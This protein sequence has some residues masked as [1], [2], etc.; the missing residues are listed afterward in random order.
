MYEIVKRYTEQYSVENERERRDE[1]RFIE[2]GDKENGA[3]GKEKAKQKEQNQYNE[4]TSFLSS[5]T[6][7]NK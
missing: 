4:L 1:N 6:A 3:T 5:R 7:Q 2:K